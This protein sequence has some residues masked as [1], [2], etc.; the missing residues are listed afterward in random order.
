M[1]WEPPENEPAH[2]ARVHNTLV[3]G[4]DSFAA[5]REQAGQLLQ[6]CP[7]L[8]GAVRETNA[9]LGRLNR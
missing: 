4:H 2:A 6:I 7:Q 3:G 9:F 5:D 8:H 1:T